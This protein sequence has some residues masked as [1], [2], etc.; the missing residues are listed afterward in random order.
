MNWPT[1]KILPLQ[2]NSS[3]MNLTAVSLFASGG[4]GDLALR[5]NGIDVLVANELLP[6][7]CE[8]L[9]YNYPETQVLEGDIWAL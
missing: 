6:D 3:Q 1:D 9:K 4:I 5:A 7:R 8:V 2:T